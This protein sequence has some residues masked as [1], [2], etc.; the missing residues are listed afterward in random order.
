MSTNVRIA[1][2]F[3][4]FAQRVTVFGFTWNR[5]ATSLGV[6]RTSAS[7]MRFMPTPL[8]WTVRFGPYW[9]EVWPVFRREAIPK[10]LVQRLEL[11]ANETLNAGI[12]SPPAFHQMQQDLQQMM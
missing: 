1:V 7:G 4:A 9:G 10:R 11:S 3:P 8:V 12:Q 5:C 2:S 6:K